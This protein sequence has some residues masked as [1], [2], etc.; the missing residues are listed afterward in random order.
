MRICPAAA[1]LRSLRAELTRRVVQ[2]ST[3]G[4]TSRAGC[5]ENT[6]CASRQVLVFGI[7]ETV[8]SIRVEPGR[9]FPRNRGRPTRAAVDLHSLGEVLPLLDPSGERG[10]VGKVV[11]EVA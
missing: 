5:A 9:S 7:E 4:P 8:R 11:Q 6:P 10:L 2:S 3:C 1:R